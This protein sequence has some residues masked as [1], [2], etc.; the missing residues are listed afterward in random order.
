MYVLAGIEWNRSSFG[1]DDLK[2]CLR[3]F[4]VP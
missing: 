2:I 3:I 1:S 4:V